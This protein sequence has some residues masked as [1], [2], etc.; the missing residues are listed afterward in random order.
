MF[1]S[2][3]KDSAKTFRQPQNLISI[4]DQIS[5]MAIRLSRDM[6]KKKKISFPERLRRKRAFGAEHK[7]L[8]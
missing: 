4:K 2:F 5:E 6:C 8:K 7:I 1:F 3:S